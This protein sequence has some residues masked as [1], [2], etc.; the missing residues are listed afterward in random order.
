MWCGADWIAELAKQ[1]VSVTCVVDVYG[2]AQWRLT[3]ESGRRPACRGLQR[4][5]EAGGFPGRCGYVVLH[6][7]GCEAGRTRSGVVFGRLERE[8]LDAVVGKVLPYLG[9][10]RGD[11]GRVSWSGI[12]GAFGV[13][14]EGAFS[15]AE[16]FCTCSVCGGVCARCSNWVEAERRFCVRAQY[17]CP[18][19]EGGAGDR[20]RAWFHEV[21]DA[22]GRVQPGGVPWLRCDHAAM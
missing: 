15:S 3:W 7:T 20:Q 1:A 16:R 14:E 19:S 6:A 11:D 5:C 2:V 21:S 17:A 9:S 10:L 13:L 12:G 4:C 8:T 22:A 18:C